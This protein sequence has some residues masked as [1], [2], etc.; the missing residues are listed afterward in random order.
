[1]FI[2][3]MSLISKAFAPYTIFGR[4]KE[5]RS[6]LEHPALKHDLKLTLNVPGCTVRFRYARL[7]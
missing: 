7:E 4:V 1:M 6:V 3:S 2:L 5:T